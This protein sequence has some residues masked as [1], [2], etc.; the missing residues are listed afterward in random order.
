MLRLRFFASF[1]DVN[2][3]Y[4]ILS[5]KMSSFLLI[6]DDRII[7]DCVVCDTKRNGTLTM[8][9]EWKYVFLISRMNNKNSYHT[10]N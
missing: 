7:H 5:W 2:P 9:H 4:C 3:N 6:Y 8:S 1:L 10:K